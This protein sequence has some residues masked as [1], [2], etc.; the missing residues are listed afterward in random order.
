MNRLSNQKF[1]RCCQIIHDSARANASALIS[2]GITEAIITEQQTILTS[3]GEAIPQERL[4]NLPPMIAP[5]VS[6]IA[7]FIAKS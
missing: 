5:T 1:I 3:F 2:Y 4:N 6:R 7:Q